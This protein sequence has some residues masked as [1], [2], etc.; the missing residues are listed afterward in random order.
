MK[1]ILKTL[2]HQMIVTSWSL[3]K[4][5][6]PLDFFGEAMT[7]IA[8]RWHGEFE[9]LTTY[10]ALFDVLQQRNFMGTFL[11]LG[12]G[13]STIFARK[14]FDEKLVKITSVDFF[15][16][17]YNR[18]LNS[19]KNTINFLKTIDSINDITVSFEQVEKSLINI[20]DRL[21]GY[22]PEDLLFNISKFIKNKEYLD[23]FRTFIAQKNSGGICQKVTE[24]DGFSSEI[25]F[26]K[27]FNALT[28]EGA[29]SRICAS[30]KPIDA[31]FFDC[32]EASSLA[33]FIE[34]EK[35][36]KSGS[37]ALLH[38]IFFPKSIKNFLLATL[39]SLDPG[40]EV[41]YMDNASKQGGLA[42]VKL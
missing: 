33:E 9:T 4:K 6:S 19:K 26:Y 8:G 12:G 34:L 27:N 15:P 25:N 14:I 28:G 3:S 38:D 35:C 30:G 10:Y 16:A 2:K 17:K 22:D 40:W 1:V 24:H 29:C 39:L 7:S 20:V 31:V 36:L 18:I 32:G 37:Y 21:L 41:L 5:N 13:Y 11:E 23:E 42:A